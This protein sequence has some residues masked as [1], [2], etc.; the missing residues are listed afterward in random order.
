M[1][2]GLYCKVDHLDFEFPNGD[3]YATYLHIDA[4]ITLLYL[5]RLSSK[6]LEIET[7]LDDPAIEFTLL[8]SQ[9]IRDIQKQGITIQNV[10]D[11]S[12]TIQ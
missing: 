4:P 12:F 6:I 8:S 9:D 10:S 2:E 1:F 5:S 7:D 3:D 11:F